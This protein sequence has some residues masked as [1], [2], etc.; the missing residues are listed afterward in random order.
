MDDLGIATAT[1]LSL[2]LVVG[3]V[4]GGRFYPQEGQKPILAITLVVSA[5][6]AFLFYAAGR[7]FWARW[8]ENSAVIEW[9]NW[10]PLLAAAAAGWVFRLPQ[11]PLWRRVGLSLLL[12]LAAV[13][14]GLWPFLGIWLRPATPAGHQLAQGI[15]LQTSWA[16]CSPAAA[17]T[18]LR[19]G[20]IE[21]TEQDLIPLCLTDSS[22]TP[23]LGLYRGVKLMANQNGRD[24]QAVSMT[25]D[26]L[27][28]DDDW[29]VLIMVKLP[30]FG[31]DLSLYADQWGWIP[32]LGHTV[33]ALGRTPQGHFVIGDPSVGRE[34]WT[35]ENLEVL[36]HGDAIRFGP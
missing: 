1:I 34:L 26:Q 29:P 6:F 10:T 14:A 23:T 22:G 7:L 4:C 3:L 9:S 30:E 31:V 16:T 35:R 27:E 18:F 8:I 20:G 5:M 13:L 19:A 32:G 2:S 17:S 28:S 36:W 24:V 12:G 11:T 15:T 33:V 25:L 21:A